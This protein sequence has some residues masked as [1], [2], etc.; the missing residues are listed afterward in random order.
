MIKTFVIYLLIYAV[1][2]YMGLGYQSDK[3]KT[4]ATLEHLNDLKGSAVKKGGELYDKLK[5]K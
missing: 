1:G 2:F 5:D 4:S 3:D